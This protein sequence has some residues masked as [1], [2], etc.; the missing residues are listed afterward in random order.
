MQPLQ[1]VAR[2]WL[3]VAVVQQNNQQHGI[4]LRLEQRHQEL[5][6]ILMFL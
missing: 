2:R 6:Q 1:Q 4:A 3:A 5:A